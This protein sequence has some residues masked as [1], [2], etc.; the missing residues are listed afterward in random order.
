[1]YQKASLDIQ[2]DSSKRHGLMPTI[3]HIANLKH[4]DIVTDPLLLVLRNALRYPSDVAYF[5]T[6][7]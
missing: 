1:M 7:S 5:L 3:V 6:K 4:T 2:A